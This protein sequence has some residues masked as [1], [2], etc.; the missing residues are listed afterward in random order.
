[1]KTS[2]I[3]Y[4]SYQKVQGSGYNS[5]YKMAA[6][7]HLTLINIFIF[8]ILEVLY[9]VHVSEWLNLVFAC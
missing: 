2:T 7:A 6:Q 1:M 3:T 5:Y 4:P 9:N 8:M